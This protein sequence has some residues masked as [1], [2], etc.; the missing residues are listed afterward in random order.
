H[1]GL[2]PCRQMTRSYSEL[3]RSPGQQS[4]IGPGYPGVVLKFPVRPTWASQHGDDRED[5]AKHICDRSNMKN[6]EPARELKK[7]HHRAVRDQHGVD[8]GITKCAM[9]RAAFGTHKLNQP[10]DDARSRKR[11]VN[12]TR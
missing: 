9:N 12:A 2:F 6:I 4:H 1:P 5:N 11:C 7:Q 10:D 8:E 3:S